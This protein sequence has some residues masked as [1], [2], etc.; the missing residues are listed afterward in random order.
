MFTLK[1]SNYYSKEA[2]QE[3][4]SASQYKD[5]VGSYGRPGCEFRAMEKINRRWQDDPSPALTIGSYVD[6]YFDGTNAFHIFRAE[7]PEIFKENGDLYAKYAVGDVL[8]NRLKKNELAMRYLSGQHQT[9]MTGELFGAP[10]KIKM[11]SY[12]P[13]KCIVDLKTTEKVDKAFWVKDLGQYVNFIQ[14]WGYEFQ[15][16]VYQEIVRQNTGE[17][18]PFCIVAVDKQKHPTVTPPVWIEQYILDD[19]LAKIEMNMPHLI[20]VKSGQEEP[21]RCGSCDCCRDLYDPTEPINSG[22]LLFSF[23]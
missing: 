3:Y 16:A 23:F 17:K 2:D 18:L 1:D 22:D 4:W 21:T 11:D 5:F 6:S 20:R 8:I 12:F 9:I 14:Y 19:A 15:G 10:W 13:G 7:H